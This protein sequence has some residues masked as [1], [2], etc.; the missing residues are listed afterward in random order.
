MK[1]WRYLALALTAS[2]V[3][4]CTTMQQVVA[5]RS[6]DFQIDRVTDLRL[7]GIDISRE[8]SSSALGVGDAARVA[9]AL[10]TRQLPLSFQ[11]RL[12]A[13][14]PASNSVTARLVRMRWTLY[15]E[16]TETIS[17]ETEHEFSLPPGQ[18]T[19]IPI[20]VSLDLLDFYER[21]GQD[22]IDLA[23]NL[24]GAGGAPKEVAVRATPT[25]DTA[26][27][28]ITYPRPITIVAGSVGRPEI[29]RA[30]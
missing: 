4:G 17:G 27:G 15:L 8:R 11:L 18:P 16:D 24:A 3:I 7:A 23:L 9:A 20:N 21:S 12:L 2:M 28:P 10:A 30:Q 25:I 14:N 1:I 26:L 29:A 5:L 13:E 6:V 22:L 19:E